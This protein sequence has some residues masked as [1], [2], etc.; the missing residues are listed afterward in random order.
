MVGGT[1]KAPRAFRRLRWCTT[2]QGV[3]AVVVAGEV[4]VV[5]KVSL[6]VTIAR[7]V[8][9]AVAYLIAN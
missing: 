3:S 9:S 5:S 7:S 6:V 8:T 1:A 2:G 4:S